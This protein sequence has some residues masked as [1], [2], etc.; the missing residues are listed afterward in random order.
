MPISRILQ[1]VAHNVAHHSASGLS[2]LHPHASKAAR[3]NGSSHLE[4][5][6][7]ATSPLSLAQI[8][9]PLRLSASSLRGKFVTI[10]NAEGFCL[11]DIS[12]AQLSMY[13]P[14]GD[15]YYCETSC[16]L[17]TLDGKVFEAK[18]ASVG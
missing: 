16:R 4:F 1:S 10:L 11:T 15:D 18:G 13:F 9:E 2:C 12:K 14:R 5:D 7:L 6:L 17:T 3:T 8:E